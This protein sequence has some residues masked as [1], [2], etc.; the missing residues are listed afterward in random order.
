[1]GYLW[2]KPTIMSESLL[3][4]CHDLILYTADILLVY[5]SPQETIMN[6]EIWSHVAIVVHKNGELMAFTD[7]EFVSVKEWIDRDALV[8]VRHCERVRPIGFDRQVLDAANRTSEILLRNEMDMQYREGFCVS[9]VLDSLGFISTQGLARGPV[10][11]EHFSSA[12]P[13]DRLQIKGYSDNWVID[14]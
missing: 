13:F 7:G 11:P 5:A 8:V 14:I 10:K 1:M 12:S 2:S 6:D 3:D 9:S 4:K